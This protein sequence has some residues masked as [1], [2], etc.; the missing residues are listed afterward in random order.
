MLIL[1]QQYKRDGL[2]VGEGARSAVCESGDGEMMRVCVELHSTVV[3][4]KRHVYRAQFTRPP[5]L[6]D[7]VGEIK[8]RARDG[9]QHI[10]GLSS[11]NPFANNILMWLYLYRHLLL[12]MGI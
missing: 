8:K 10:S 7:I 4:G 11:G 9:G 12:R 2:I 1:N 3:E 5:P 6:D